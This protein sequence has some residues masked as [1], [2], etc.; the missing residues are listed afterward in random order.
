MEINTAI[1]VAGGL[2]TRLRPLTETIPKPLIP[3]HGKPII[4]HT[5][6]NL[7]KHGVK[8]IILSI[9]YR[10]ELIKEHFQDGEK[11]G[12]SI[13]YSIETEPLGTGGAVK[14]AAANLTAPFILVWG[15]NL[16]DIDYGRL[17]EEYCK[18]N[19]P[20]IM[21]LTPREDVENFGAARLDGNK[22]MAFIEK[23][24]R[25]EAPSNL[26][27]AGAFIIEPKCLNIL[28]EGKS[29]L[30]KDCFEKLAP[31]GEISAFVH[32]G[33]WF[34]TDTLEKYYHA[35]ANF[36]P[37]IDFKKKKIIIA[38][39]DDTVCESC[40]CISPEMAGQISKMIASGYEFAFISGTK[41]SDLM[42]MISS[43]LSGKH[44][45]LATTGS[46]YTLVDNG[47][48]ANVYNLSFT[49]E[50]KKEIIT[51]FEKLIADYNIQSLTT[52]EDQLQDR[53]SQITLSAIGRKAPGELKAQY[54]P[55]GAKR[56][57]WLEFLRQQLPEGKYD[58]KIGGTTSID[59]TRK[60]LD[61]EWGIR[62]FA[63]YNHFPLDEI[64]FFGDKL[65]PGGNDFAATNIV[66]CLSVKNPTDTLNKLK[67]IE[68]YGKIF[69]DERPWGSFEQFTCNSPSTVKIISVQAGKRLSL[70]SHEKR[71]ELWT[72]LD[73]NVIVE[74]DGAVKIL[75]NGEKAFIPRH[76][77]HRLSAGDKDIHILEISFGE[78]DEND[79]A[80]YEDDFGRK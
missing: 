35:N 48:P 21:A 73:D 28:P 68:C 27:N 29:S 43:G 46:N 4:E 33:Q 53:D 10:A 3:V 66:D 25:E 22:I 78:F 24:Q 9:G 51:A 1:I 30:E 47:V 12:V 14:L 31:L 26:I 39:V 23:P 71:D 49:P 74:I 13:S 2:G 18:N 54:D 6:L 56:L 45:L 57:L 63:E 50:E 58:F 38:D 40:Q 61:K 5:I 59:V 64:L 17:Q 65:H 32:D 75:K 11:L 77:R 8:N 76:S 15:D 69:A 7:K 67:E 42:S 55:D 70:Q 52:K 60:G 36:R 79:V 80:R 62:K 34:P 37:E 41:C 20:I 19:T 16:M 72:A 44:H